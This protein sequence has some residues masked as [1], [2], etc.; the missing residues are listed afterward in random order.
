M[1]K[2]FVEFSKAYDL[3]SDIVSGREKDR[4]N[5]SIFLI[6]GSQDGTGRLPQ[7]LV[8]WEQVTTE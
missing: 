3:Y 1:E 6:P 2:S 5:A 8:K 4:K 7:Y